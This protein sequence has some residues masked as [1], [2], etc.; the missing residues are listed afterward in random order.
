MENLYS[1]AVPNKDDD[2]TYESSVELAYAQLNNYI[3]YNLGPWKPRHGEV[4]YTP[5]PF[6]VKMYV[7]R[8][9]INQPCDEDAYARGIVFKKWIVARYMCVK[10]TEYA[11][12][13]R[14]K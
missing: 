3:E 13:E 1:L 9:W 10:M 14:R 2:S 4:Y 8:K 6:R 7:M 12:M 5:D 11:R